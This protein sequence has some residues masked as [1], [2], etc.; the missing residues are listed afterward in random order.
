MDVNKLITL[1]NSIEDKSVEVVIRVGPNHGANF[2]T[3]TGHWVAMDNPNG[4]RSLEPADM[5]LP[6]SSYKHDGYIDVLV[7]S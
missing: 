6:D 4:T 1:L 5:L 7:L 3:R 2:V